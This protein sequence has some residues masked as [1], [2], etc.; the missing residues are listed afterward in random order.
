MNL[1]ATAVLLLYMRTLDYLAAQ[2]HA[3]PDMTVAAMGDSSPIVHALGAIAVLL[4]ALVLSVYKPR[5]L[6]RRG[7]RHSAA[8]PR[9]SLASPRAG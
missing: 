8:T 2:A 9:R 7:R 1:L 4:V 5:G 6:T 3:A